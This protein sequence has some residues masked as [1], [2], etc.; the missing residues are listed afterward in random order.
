MAQAST[1]RFTQGPGTLGRRRQWIGM[2]GAAVAIALGVYLFFF[3]DHGPTVSQS[4]AP[5]QSS[6]SGWLSRLEPYTPAPE[7]PP[8]APG[9]DP[10]LEALA[11]QMEELTRK[12]TAME[13]QKPPAA[14]GGQPPRRK[15]KDMGFQEN[16]KPKDVLNG[17]KTYTLAPWATVIPCQAY[18]KVKSTTGEVGTAK[19]TTTVYDT[20]TGQIPL[21]PQNS[22]VGYRYDTQNLLHGDDRMLTAAIEL[23]LP[24]G[25]VVDL[26][27]APVTDQEGITGLVSHVDQRF[28]FL[29]R[30]VLIQG[31]LGR[32]VPQAIQQA[33]AG[34]NP[35]GQIPSGV[36]QSGGQAVTQRI[37]PALNTK[38]I[39]TINPG[40]L[41]TVLLTKALELPAAY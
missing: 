15:H 37:A 5:P 14:G 34:S 41:C 9:R 7:K 23:T 6:A 35:L 18:T 20:A 16:K 12:I 38:P 33:T 36:A 24:S 27:E 39:V 30:A 4:S 32:G 13:K 2:G 10:A 31:V 19:V 28:W 11:R 26:G 25:E 29:A 21:I 17:P 22:T 40:E 3:R 8:V 1:F